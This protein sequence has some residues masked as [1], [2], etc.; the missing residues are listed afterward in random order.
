M[1]P[2]LHGEYSGALDHFTARGNDKQAMVHEETDRTDFLT[3]LGQE[4]LPQRSRSVKSNNDPFSCL[5][6]LA[7]AVAS[8]TVYSM[9]VLVGLRR[10]Q[11][12]LHSVCI[13]E[14][15]SS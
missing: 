11:R 9:P 8:N 3:Q 14:L 2:Q 1:A 7:S 12:S 4:I 5:T 15:S 10:R 13:E 6:T